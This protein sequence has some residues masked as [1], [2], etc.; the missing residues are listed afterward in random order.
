M[1]MNVSNY[2]DRHIGELLDEKKL[3]AFRRV[4]WANT[5]TME[6][7][8]MLQAEYIAGV[9][10]GEKVAEIWSVCNSNRRETK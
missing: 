6:I 4:F 1:N 2:L 5:A 8:S 7:Y 10:N 3:F 9:I